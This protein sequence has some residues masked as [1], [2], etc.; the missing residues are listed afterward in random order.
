MAHQAA[1]A[2]FIGAFAL[3]SIVGFVAARWN[4]AEHAGLHEWGLAGRR[5]GTVLSWFLIGG[6]L[7][8]AYTF[9]AIPALVYGA[10][11]IGFY[12]VP[13]TILIYPLIFAVMPRLW[14]ICKK[15]DYIT[16]ADFVRGR[17]QSRSLALSGCRYRHSCDHALHRFAIGRHASR[18]QRPWGFQLPAY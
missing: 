17:F 18:H 6:D 2:V 8:T 12:G 14:S 7:Y 13:Y 9:I 3:V 15:Y 16:A 10:G 11:A 1:A 5:F 4:R